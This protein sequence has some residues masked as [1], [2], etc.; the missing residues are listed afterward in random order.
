MKKVH[1]QEQ[2]ESY[3]MQKEPRG[4]VCMVLSAQTKKV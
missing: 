3:L 2:N 1:S 4:F